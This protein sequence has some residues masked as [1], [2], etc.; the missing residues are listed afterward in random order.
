MAA[1]QNPAPPR[2][3][4]SAEHAH[5]ARAAAYLLGAGVHT[6]ADRA[7]A[8]SLVA[9]WPRWTA[10]LR[11]SETFLTGTLRTLHGDG[12]DQ[13]IDLSPVLPTPDGPYRA[14]AAGSGMRLVRVDPDAVTAAQTA[15]LMRGTPHRVVQC[16]P[17]DP[18]AAL[19]LIHHHRLLDLRRPVV[20][21]AGLGALESRPTGPVLEQVLADWGRALPDGSLLVFTHDSDDARTPTETRAARRARARHAQ[22]GWA[23]TARSGATVKVSLRNADWAPTEPLTWATRS[24]TPTHNTAAHSSGRPDGRAASVLAGIAVYRPRHAPRPVDDD[25]TPAFET[26][27]Q[28]RPPVTDPAQGRH[29]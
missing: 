18:D 8:E 21:L 27:E 7:F 25:R 15:A 20:L 24:P 17:D 3:T 28:T 12:V 5:P 29:R 2:T 10:D 11:A 4:T 22:I 6:Q 23:F 9:R 19:T 1:R 14:F 13:V 16:D 26:P